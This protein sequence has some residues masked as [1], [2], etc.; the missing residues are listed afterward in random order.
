[1]AV[2]LYDVRNVTEIEAERTSG[3]CEDKSLSGKHAEKEKR[4]KRDFYKEW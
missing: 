2:G 1:M 3:E 4:E